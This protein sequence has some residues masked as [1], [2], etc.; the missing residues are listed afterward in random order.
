MAI[1]AQSNHMGIIIVARPELGAKHSCPEC[2]KKFYDLNRTPATC[3]YCGHV[4]ESENDKPEDKEIPEVEENAEIKAP[5]TGDD[6][7]D[8]EAG[9]IDNAN[10]LADL[11]DDADGGD[12]DD[13]VVD[14]GK[15]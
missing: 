6:F 5:E 15:T 7:N 9:V 8:D 11:A 12:T 2:E 4:I 13:K 1:E 3:P 14:E 10:D